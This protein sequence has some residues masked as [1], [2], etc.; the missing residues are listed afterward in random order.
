MSGLR[1]QS[2]QQEL[3][4]RREVSRFGWRNSLERRTS[5]WV[6]RHKSDV[7]LTET[8]KKRIRHLSNPAAHQ[9]LQQFF[10]CALVQV[11]LL[12]HH[13]LPSS[14]VAPHAHLAQVVEAP[15]CDTELT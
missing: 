10:L 4:T 15:P 1:T 7:T 2:W 6:L 3:K 5:F 11:G 8:I 13:Q 14:D 12:D 9:E